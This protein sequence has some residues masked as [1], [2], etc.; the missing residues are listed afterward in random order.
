MALRPFNP[1]S[2]VLSLCRRPPSIIPAWHAQAVRS[3][4]ALQARERRARRARAAAGAACPPPG[5][6]MQV[7]RGLGGGIER[8]SSGGEQLGQRDA[9]CPAAPRPRPSGPRGSR[10]RGRGIPSHTFGKQSMSPSAPA[11]TP[12]RRRRRTARRTRAGG[13]SPRSACCG[14]W[15]SRPLLSLI[16]TTLSRSA[17]RSAMAGRDGVPRIAGDVV[18]Q[19]WAATAGGVDRLEMR[20]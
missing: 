17:S 14:S 20:E 9:P 15:S 4:P 6:P 5:R 19:R 3:C 8:A 11:S 7:H 16:A 13:P 10:A 18:E 2:I 12:A 1:R